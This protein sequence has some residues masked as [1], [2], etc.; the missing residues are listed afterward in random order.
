MNYLYV[1]V[2]SGLILG[3]LDSNF[4]WIVYKESDEKKPSEIIHKEIH[5]IIKDNGV[6][7]N[8]LHYFF[9]SGP[10]S[11]TGM[12]LGEGIAQIL[13]WSKATVYSFHQFEV[14]Q[15]MGIKKGYWITNAFKGQAFIYHWDQDSS[16]IEL[17]NT[18]D[19]S[20]TDPTSGYT[21]AHDNE[22]FKN[23]TTSKSMI[24]KEPAMFFKKISELKMR[25]QPYYF[26]T[27][28][29]EFKQC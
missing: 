14:P 27:L 22:L 20:I 21:L 4:N 11:Y 28:E 13:E 19:V 6:D 10:G 16:N 2:T 29:E 3:L 12:R 18:A 5:E 25:K 7:K 23:L 24:A 1:D 17:I 9:S 26:R 8:Q 15:L